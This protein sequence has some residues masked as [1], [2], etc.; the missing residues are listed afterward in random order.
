MRSVSGWRWWPRGPYRWESVGDDGWY[1]DLVRPDGTVV[2]TITAPEDRTGARDLWAIIGEL[3]MIAEQRDS[4]KAE[5]ER[6][7][8]ELEDAS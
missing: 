7:R 5:N 2:T 8:K 4:L 3:N 6:L 1:E